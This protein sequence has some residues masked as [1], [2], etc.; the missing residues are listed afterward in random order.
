M[1]HIQDRFKTYMNEET[2]IDWRPDWKQIPVNYL[3]NF[4]DSLQIHVV[5][6]IITHKRGCSFGAQ[7]VS[8]QY[9]DIM[10]IYNYL[11]YDHE[12]A[13]FDYNANDIADNFFP[14]PTR[15]DAEIAAFEKAFELAETITE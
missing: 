6:P 7:V 8:R 14:F 4:F 1:N 15:R 11:D 5:A 3:Y 10:V 12:W 9:G 13:E 2:P